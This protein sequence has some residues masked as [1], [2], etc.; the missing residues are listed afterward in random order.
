[1][2]P[3]ANRCVPLL[4][5]ALLGACAHTGGYGALHAPDHAPELSAASGNDREMYLDLIRQMQQRGLF[6]ASLAHI[7]AYRAAHGETP[8]LRRLEADAL[9]ETG[10]ADIALVRYRGLLDTNEAA[11]A[12]HG[13]GLVEA[14]RSRWNEAIEALE[15]AVKR[16]PIDVACLGDLGYA[17][18]RAGDVA[19]AREPL[20]KAA[21]L[22]PANAKA[23]ANLALLFTVEGDPA[24]AER[25]MQS[26]ALTPTARQAIARMA[27]EWQAGQRTASTERAEPAQRAAGA[28]AG[29]RGSMLERFGAA[30]ITQGENSDVR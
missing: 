18:L 14:A 1:M 5:I 6:Y 7:D 4:C 9:R 21:E 23:A 30:A 22:D 19:G 26:G 28:V 24:R 27:T 11:A 3:I 16:D 29:V 10:Q 15:E 17:R 13:I 8:A 25:L 12:W 20:A 2:P